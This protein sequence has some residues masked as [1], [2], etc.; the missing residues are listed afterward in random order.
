M[1][2]SDNPSDAPADSRSVGYVNL[3]LQQGGDTGAGGEALPNQLRPQE[4][5]GPGDGNLHRKNL[6]DIGKKIP[7]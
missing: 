4:A 7:A 6:E 2:F 1:F 3:G 5:V